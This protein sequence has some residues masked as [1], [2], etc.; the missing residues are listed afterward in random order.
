MPPP[1]DPTELAALARKYDTILALRR[2][3]GATGEVASREVLRALAAEFPG[4][5]FELDRMALDE[6][7]R[8]ADALRTHPHGPPDFAGPMVFW[9]RTLRL[10]LA[11]RRGEDVH[12]VE[13]DALVQQRGRNL[14]AKMISLVAARYA[15]SD[16]VMAAR[17]FGSTEVKASGEGG[18]PL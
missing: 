14:R 11:R 4:A 2:A 3:Y 8:R 17:L 13:L 18:G 10:W 5:L 16:E 6:V 15:V 9:H 7:Q 12:D 1:V